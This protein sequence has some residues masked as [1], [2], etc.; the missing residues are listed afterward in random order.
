MPAL[1]PSHTAAIQLKIE[2]TTYPS[3]TAHAPDMTRSKASSKK[4]ENVV[5]PPQNPVTRN[6]LR[7]GE[8]MRR[9]DQAAIS[10][11]RADPAILAASV[12]AKNQPGTA[13]NDSSDSP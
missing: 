5:N 4:A 11:I 9:T 7:M 10:P 13:D 8:G 1:Q 12:P 6:P 3:A 2:A